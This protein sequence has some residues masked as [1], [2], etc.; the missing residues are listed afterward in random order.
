MHDC[1][2]HVVNGASLAGTHV[3]KPMALQ[4][5][6][7]MN[8]RQRRRVVRIAKPQKELATRSGAFGVVVQ[9]MVAAR[10][11]TLQQAGEVRSPLQ[12][13]KTQTRGNTPEVLSKAASSGNKQPFRVLCKSTSRDTAKDLKQVFSLDSRFRSRGRTRR[14]GCWNLAQSLRSAAAIWHVFD[15]RREGTW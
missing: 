12:L 15:C 2:P 10:P 9:S 11:S 13:P 7:A 1:I 4:G 14:N 5:H 6:A 8:L 3:M